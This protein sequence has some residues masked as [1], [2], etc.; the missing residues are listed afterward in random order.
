MLGAE[1]KCRKLRTGKVDY[2]PET[3]A[4]GKEL[5]FWRASL[6]RKQGAKI[7]SRL[8]QSLKKAA[9]VTIPTKD[10]SF[11]DINQFIKSASDRYREAKK[12]A[13]SNRETYLD[14]L[15]IKIRTRY[16]RVES[17]RRQGRVARAINGKLKGGA[18][19]MVKT[20][21]PNGETLVCSTKPTLEKAIISG[22]K[23]NYSRS[24]DTP[25]NPAIFCS[26][27]SL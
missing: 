19:S 14:T 20:L 22:N 12:Q 7:H 15:P 2:S 5:R 4:P 17:Q 9:N 25:P 1:K 8:W 3:M 23:G 21:G 24:T 10:L 27:L 18:V 11:D 26:R 16:L 13:P 6:A